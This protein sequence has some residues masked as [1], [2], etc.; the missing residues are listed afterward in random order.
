M[1]HAGKGI[2]ARQRK[3]VPV[4]VW[5]FC[6]L[7]VEGNSEAV[8]FLQNGISESPRLEFACGDLLS[9]D[10]NNNSNAGDVVWIGDTGWSSPHVGYDDFC[11]K[12]Y[13]KV[14]AAQERRRRTSPNTSA[15]WPIYIV[16]FT[17][18]PRQQ[19]CLNVE[20]AVGENFV[21]YSKRSIV[22]GRD[23]N[24]EKGW[25]NEGAFIKLAADESEGGFPTYK[26]ISYFVRT[27]IVE[28]LQF[29]LRDRG[30][31][32]RDAIE[33]LDRSVDVTHLWPLNSHDAPCRLR[34]LVSDVVHDL[35]NT[36]GLTVQVGFVGP[37]SEP[38]RR[39]VA[40]EYVDAMLRTKIMVVTQRDKWQDHYR[41]FEAMVVGP[42]IMTDRMLALPAGLENGT[43]IVEFSSAD[44][45]RS[46]ID[47]YLKHAEER[48]TIAARGRHVAM[49]QHRSWHRI[50]EVIFGRALTVCSENPTNCPYIVHANKTS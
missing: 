11:S 21:F 23:W 30:L 22:T 14:A 44:E 17:D 42:L 40:R 3:P 33:T 10:D 38:G 15:S 7:G 49:T 35:G 20:Q 2:N 18:S 32:L 24:E 13:E 25:V 9:D 41:L 16:D 8:H 48:L 47:Y 46:L 27:D 43:S 31:E 29:S 5:P 26:H 1:V 19:R 34:N 4:A 37:A 50:E 12:F 45:L 39:G 28:S 36:E 6:E